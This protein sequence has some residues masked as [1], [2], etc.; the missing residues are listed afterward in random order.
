[1]SVKTR[2][3]SRLP[4][5]SRPIERVLYQTV[6]IAAV[7]IRPASIAPSIHRWNEDF[8]TVYHPM[9]R[10]V[11]LSSEKDDFPASPN[12]RCLAVRPRRLLSIFVSLCRVDLNERANR[13]S[14]R[15]RRRAVAKQDGR[16]PFSYQELE[17]CLVLGSITV[18]AAKRVSPP[19]TQR[20]RPNEWTADKLTLPP[21]FYRSLFPPPHPAISPVLSHLVT[22]NFSVGAPTEADAS[23]YIQT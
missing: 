7:R 6:V 9:A 18:M 19:G 17:P 22:G 20:P 8:R 16:G 12:L 23:P 21:S 14:I 1:M 2:F 3:S 15:Q 11:H 10:D 13:E 5:F 4:R